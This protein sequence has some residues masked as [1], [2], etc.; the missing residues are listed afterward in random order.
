[1]HLTC[2]KYIVLQHKQEPAW[3]TYAI[4]SIYCTGNSAVK[5]SEGFW[6]CVLIGRH[7][8]A[9]SPGRA[10]REEVECDVLATPRAQR[11]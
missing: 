7:D 11:R 8:G 3:H 1:M 10:L 6:G 9:D 2:R 5:A 4:K